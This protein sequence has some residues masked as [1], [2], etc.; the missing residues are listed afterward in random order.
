[1]TKISQG[2]NPVV[3]YLA[4]KRE[5]SLPSSGRKSENGHKCLPPKPIGGVTLSRLATMFEK[6]KKFGVQTNILAQIT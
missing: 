3:V 1:V 4:I 5:M 6:F 2:C